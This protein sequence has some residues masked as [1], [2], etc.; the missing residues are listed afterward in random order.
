MR[1]GPGAKPM[2]K[3]W[4]TQIVRRLR[5]LAPKECKAVDFPLGVEVTGPEASRWVVTLSDGRVDTKSKDPVQV[6]LLVPQSRLR[7]LA[8]KMRFRP[9]KEAF[10]NRDLQ[11][12]SE[13]PKLLQ[14]LKPVAKAVENAEAA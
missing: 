8:L 1:E 13:D 10:E 2:V 3:S 7:V 9:W 12:E 14:K 11:L 6:T 4:L 5:E